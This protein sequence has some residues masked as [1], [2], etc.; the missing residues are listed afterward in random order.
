MRVAAVQMLPEVG[1]FEGNLSKIE[2]YTSLAIENGVDVLVFPELTISGYTWDEDVLKKAVLFFKDVAKKRLLR[3]SREG[4]IVLV[5]GTPREVFGKLRNSVVVFKKKRELLFYD[6]THLFREEKGVFE[7]GEHLLAFSY[8]G[9][10]FGVLICYELEF[11]EVSR[12]LTLKG[13]KILLSPSAFWKAGEYPYDVVTRARALEN[14]IFVVVASTCGKGSA[15]F[16]GRSRIVFPDGSVVK[17]IV[18]GEGLVFEDVDSD[19][20]YR[21]RYE[22]E[23]YPALMSNLRKHLY[24]FEKGRI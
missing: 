8:K 22:E 9:V 4:Q 19:V 2:H 24:T 15:E 16:V 23:N 17:E 20:V 14:G 1:N 11:P 7:P 10:V 21:Y 18:E 3:L 12:V 5:V 6:K 13:S